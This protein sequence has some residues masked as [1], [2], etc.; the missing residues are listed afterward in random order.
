MSVHGSGEGPIRGQHVASVK[1]RERHIGGVVRGEIV[2]ELEHPN[3]ELLVPMPREGQIEIILHRFFGS[4]FIQST[5]KH[6]S[7]ESGSHL[8]I[9]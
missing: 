7:T 8:D 9:A 6:G 1:L 2:P 5:E 3:D 4:Q